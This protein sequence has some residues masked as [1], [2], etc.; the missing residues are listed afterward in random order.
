MMPENCSRK[1]VSR[2]FDCLSKEI[3]KQQPKNVIHFMVDFLCKNYG[4]HL[5]G[6]AHVWDVGGRPNCGKTFKHRKKEKC[7]FFFFLFSI[8][9]LWTC[10]SD[11]ELEKEKK[12]VIEFFKSQKLTTEIAKHFISVGF[13]SMESLLYLNAHVLDDIE[14]FNNV[15]WL[16]GHK[17]R[18][19]VGESAVDSAK[20]LPPGTMLRGV[21]ASI[22]GIIPRIFPPFLIPP[23]TIPYPPTQQ[24]FSNIQENIKTFYAEY[25]KDDVKCGLDYSAL[26]VSPGRQKRKEKKKKRKL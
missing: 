12:L 8:F 22:G 11:L 5:R 13:D 1:S 7:V 25:D 2:L 16:P 24:M 21:C 20:E 17:I 3:E 15:N 19:Q 23:F 18:L 9:S 6:F 26:R 4:S 14:K 10:F